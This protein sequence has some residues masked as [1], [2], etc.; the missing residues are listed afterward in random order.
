[1]LSFKNLYWLNV[2]VQCSL[3]CSNLFQTVM[4]VSYREGQQERVSRLWRQETRSPDPLGGPLLLSMMSIE[5]GG[6][7]IWDMRAGERLEIFL[8]GPQN[9]MREAL[10]PSVYPS[11]PPS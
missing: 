7:V 6:G 11:S 5:G 10:H 2:S 1:M 8:L 4:A 9:S 3:L